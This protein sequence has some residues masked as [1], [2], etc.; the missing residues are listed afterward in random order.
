[1]V[2]VVALGPHPPGWYPAHDARVEIA[3]GLC[4]AAIHPDLAAAHELVDQAAR[5]ALELAEQEVVQ[6]LAVTVFGHGNGAGS[7]PGGCVGHR[8]LILLDSGG[9]VRV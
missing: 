1:G 9:D 4:S 8:G 6:P 5:G 3:Y 2:A 7:G